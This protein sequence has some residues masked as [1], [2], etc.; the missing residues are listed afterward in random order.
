MT[1]IGGWLRSLAD[2]YDRIENLVIRVLFARALPAIAGDRL[3][4]VG[5]FRII[6]RVS[7]LI[8]VLVLVVAV[9]TLNAKLLVVSGMLFDLAGIARIFID[10][11]WSD[12][13]SA[14]TDE[15][16]YPYG[17]P[18]YV[19][20]ELFKDEDPDALGE[21]PEHHEP[22]ARHFYWRRGLA[23]VLVGFLLQLIGTVLG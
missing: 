18:S 9:L 11:E 21:I 15:N 1:F 16:A 2:Q 19:T 13:L 4:L 12:L 22:M 3:Q 17:P 14:Y 10:E 8:A 20:R 7:A 23:M 6:V 5:M